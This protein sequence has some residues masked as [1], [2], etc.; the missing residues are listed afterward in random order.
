[1][2]IKRNPPSTLRVECHLQARKANAWSTRQYRVHNGA[3]KKLTLVGHRGVCTRANHDMG[4]GTGGIAD[5]DEN[6]G[7]TRRINSVVRRA[8]DC[9]GP[10]VRGQDKVHEH[11][12][13]AR[14]ECVGR[15]AKVNEGD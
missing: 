7:R 11:Q 15:E 5:R 14:V 2:F 1:M 9:E 6:I 13:T 3:E 10:S 4:S 8:S 12:A